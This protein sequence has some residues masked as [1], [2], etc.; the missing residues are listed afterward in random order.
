MHKIRYFSYTNR[1][2]QLKKT[3]LSFFEKLFYLCRVKHSEI[4]QHIIK[5]ASTLFY[6]NGYNSTG[7]N[8]IIAEAGIAKATL[9]SHFKSKEDVC[10]AYL[11]FK[12]STFLE[13]IAKFCK[14]KPT[15]KQQILAIFDFLQSF[16]LSSDFNGCW[17]INTV[18]EIP[19]DNEKIRMEIQQQ[20]EK[21][22]GLISDLVNNNLPN[23]T[24]AQTTSLSKQIYLLYESAV[25]E[26][27]LH[28][29][30]WPIIET[31]KLCSQII[32]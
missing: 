15:G 21:F 28:K 27:H 12:N 18:S 20:K 14:S 17:C 5:T 1:C 19:K 29:A 26:S 8:E 30:D 11:K 23:L 7:I 32:E 3:S 25:S 22:I 4:R 2:E 24:K 10:V 16:F 13:D 31:R 9:Y 6:G